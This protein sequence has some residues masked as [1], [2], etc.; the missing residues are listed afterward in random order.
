MFVLNKENRGYLTPIQFNAYAKLAQ[1]TVFDNMFVKYR[2]DNVK[3]NNR[4]HALEFGDEKK[5]IKEDIERFMKEEQLFELDGYFLMPEDCYYTLQLI[6]NDSIEIEEAEK[7]KMLTYLQNS[8]LAAPSRCYPVYSKYYDKYLVKPDTI[9]DCV[10]AVYVRKLKDPKW[11]YQTIQR[12]PVF[13]P[14]DISYQDFEL[15][16]DYANDIIAEILKLAGLQLQDQQVL[17]ASLAYE[18]NTMAKEK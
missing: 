7:N 15:Q 14:S 2:N 4:I 5:K 6:W 1:Q 11:T 16:E 18:Q 3:K 17:Q 12:N 13:N 10:T 8:T 9:I